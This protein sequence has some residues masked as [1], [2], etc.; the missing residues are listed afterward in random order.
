MGQIFFRP[1]FSDNI[2]QILLYLGFG[3][4][5]LGFGIGIWDLDSSWPTDPV[6]QLGVAQ[7]FQIFYL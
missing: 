5:D 2:N 6:D 3:I 7:V 4:W 1:S